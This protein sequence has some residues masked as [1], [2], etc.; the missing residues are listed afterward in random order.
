MW[1]AGL[2]LSA[3][4]RAGTWRASRSAW[5]VFALVAGSQ[6]WAQSA[7]DLEAARRQSEAVQRQQQ[8]QLRRDQE[9]AQPPDKG[10]GGIDTRKLLPKLDASKA[11]TKCRGISEIVINGAP[12]LTASLR[13]KISKTYV[14]GCLGTTEIVEILGEITRDY[15]LRGYV[16]TRAYL[17][18]QDLSGGKLE[19]LVVEGMIETL[20][21]DGGPQR[22]ISPGNTFPAKPGDLLNLR[23]LEQGIDQINRLSSNKATLD[24]QP[25]SQPGLSEVIIR[26]DPGPLY[27]AV[28]TA[29]NQGSAAT[30]RHQL[31][32]TL[33]LDSLLGLTEFISFTRRV[34]V[35]NTSQQH[36]TSNSLIVG[37]PF[38]YSTLSYNASRSRYA[39][40]VQ[41]P[42]GRD[43]HT[44]GDSSS[45]TLALDRVV[46]RDQANRA[47]ITGAFTH[48]KTRNF[49]EGQLLGV[50]SRTLSVLD[51][52]GGV[53]TR[54]G[55]GA[56]SMT[57][58][59][60]QG[61]TA[62][63]ALRDIDGLPDSAPRAQFKKIKY[64]AS[65]S[66]PWRWLDSDWT[67]SSQLTGQVART[68]LFGSEQIS[69]GGIYSVRGHEKN[70]LSGDSGYFLRNELSVRAPVSLAETQLPLRLFVGLDAG[71][72]RNR[73]PDV[74]QGSLAGSAFGATLGWKAVSAELF[75]TCPLAVPS[76]MERESC[77][78]WFRLNVSI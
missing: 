78:T 29:D 28:S 74:P 20:R 72:G 60:A 18:T 67:L 75:A 51:L 46:Y 22:G 33:S 64:T 7:T 15:V 1:F 21:V 58:G 14:G 9:A 66:L 11:G 49:L 25:G 57:L 37:V 62:G 43:L 13:Q 53:T 39:S 54:L 41:A 61:L 70:A 38:G 40:T 76:A 6:A 30:G 73:A 19:L 24:I 65:Y 35:P 69:I 68:T 31:G 8:E 59:W 42:S 36:A 10:P 52:D 47:T 17:P 23:D 26:N 44:A 77:Q 45:N 3:A 56:L 2:A 4:C 12:H 55:Q 50:S 34:S 5:L 16:S 27:H 71:A 63:G 48:K 32:A